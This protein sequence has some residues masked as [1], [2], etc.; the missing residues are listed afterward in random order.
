MKW[1]KLSEAIKR[2]RKELKMTQKQLAEGICTQAQI[3]KLENQEELPSSITL[4]QI[5]QK[6]EVDVEYFFREIDNERIDYIEEVQSLARKYIRN[7]NYPLL[8]E[9]IDDEFK[10]DL[11]QSNK[12]YQQFLLWHKGI[13]IYYIE[14]NKSKSLETLNEA[15]ALTH[16]QQRKF[17]TEREIE[18]LN[19]IAIIYNEE[20]DFVQSLQLYEEAIYYIEKLPKLKDITIYLRLLYGAA[21]QQLKLD[22]IQKSLSFSEKGIHLCRN[23]E[24]LYLLGELYYEKA[25]CLAKRD[26]P[27]AETFFQKS[28]QIF[29]VEDKLP[30]VK[31]VNEEYIQF[32]EALIK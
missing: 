8:K 14:K 13:C 17:Y 22:N 31:I 32:K 21:K 1:Y 11:F 2:L 25:R 19:S 20:K 26:D 23:N 6:L 9:L 4:Y 27:E 28:M 10:N 18:I 16:D 15:I 30:Y 3:S 5:A 24:S 29:T 7:K 12:E